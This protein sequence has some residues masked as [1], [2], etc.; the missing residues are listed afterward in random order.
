MP[1]PFRRFPVFCRASGR[2]ADFGSMAMNGPLS[3][4]V[5]PKQM[6]PALLPTPLSPMRGPVRRQKLGIRCFPILPPKW[7][8]GSITGARTGIRFRPRSVRLS[9]GKPSIAVSVAFRFRDRS[10]LGGLRLKRSARLAA[11]HPIGSG[12]S[13]RPWRISFRVPINGWPC[14]GRSLSHCRPP[15]PRGQSPPYRFELELPFRSSP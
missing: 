14:S 11:M 8:S 15:G 10:D 6:G 12:R 1:L 7:M 2:P 3:E 13:F 4:R 9:E 5:G